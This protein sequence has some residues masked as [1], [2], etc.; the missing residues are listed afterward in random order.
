MP[1]IESSVE[2]GAPPAT[3]FPW[4]VDPDRLARWI[5][6]FIGSEP[7]GSGEVRVGSRSHD[8]IEAEGRR[9][10]VETEIVE[11]RTGER[12]AVRIT[13]SSHDQFD[14]YDL[15]GRDG[16]TELTYR[17]DV[18]MRGFMRLLSPLVASQLRARAEGPGDAEAR[19]RRRHGQ[20]LTTATSKRRVADKSNAAR[21][22]RRGAVSYGERRH[23]DA[24]PMS[25]RTRC[26][27]SSAW[28]RS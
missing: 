6:G 26:D 25:W 27:P 23:L 15:D 4:L 7:I 18:R 10:E 19:G 16:A 24:S 5:G 14:S 17:S 9:F 28:R 11:L 22:Q 13:S 2:I 3:V 21:R 1:R 8:T 12:L 20:S